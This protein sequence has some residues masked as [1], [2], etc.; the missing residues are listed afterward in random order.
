M[1]DAVQSELEQ[2][3]QSEEEVKQLKD[4]MVAIHV[5]VVYTCIHIRTYVYVNTMT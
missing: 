1:A 3:K 2:Y 4:A 5:Y